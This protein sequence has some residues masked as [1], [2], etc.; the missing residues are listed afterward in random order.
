MKKTYIKPATTPVTYIE[1]LSACCTSYET[2]GISNEAWSNKK[3]YNNHQQESPI[4][5]NMRED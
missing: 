5:R 1:P 3:N 4:W 2:T